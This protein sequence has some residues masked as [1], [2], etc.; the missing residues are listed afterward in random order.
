[1]HGSLSVGISVVF[2]W[3]PSHVGLAG[4]SAA[5]IAAKAA[6]LLQV[7][8]LTIPHSDCNSLIRT[9]AINQWQVRWNSQT[10]NIMHAIEPTVSVYPA[11]MRILI[12]G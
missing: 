1:V 4:N 6:Q 9:K 10:Q 5:D 8:N 11:E 2:M 12:T 3:V 7:S